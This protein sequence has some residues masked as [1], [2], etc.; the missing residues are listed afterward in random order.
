MV[1]EREI[2][3]YDHQTVL[4]RF[5]AQD[6]EFEV[7]QG[8]ISAMIS[9]DQIE[10]LIDGGKTMYTR[11]GDVEM[12]VDGLSTEF[13]SMEVVVDGATGEITSLKS[14][15]GTLKSTATAFESRLSS[16]EIDVTNLGDDLSTNYSTTAQMNSAIEQSAQGITQTVS[17][18]YQTKQAAA[19]DLSAAKTYADGAA[20]TAESNAATTAQN[21]VDS[22]AQTLRGE[23]AQALSGYTTLTAAQSMIDQSATGIRQ[24]VSGT[25]ITK[26][27]AANDIANGVQD[28]KDYADEQLEG[29]TTTEQY[30]TLSTT[31]DGISTE[32]GKKVGVSE[33]ISRINQSPEQIT[34]EASRLDLRGV[35]TVSQVETAQATANSALVQEQLIYLSMPAGTTSTP[36]PSFWVEVSAP[37]Q[38]TWTTT[39]PPYNSSYPV[40][41]V[42]TQ[43]KTSA[44]TVSCTTPV[45]DRTTTVIDGG[46]IIANSVTADKIMVN[47]VLAQNVLARDV[48]ASGL[49]DFNNRFYRL[50]VDGST[51]RVVLVSTYGISLS[52]PRIVIGSD[53]GSVININGTPT[54]NGSTLED[55]VISQA[56]SKD[57]TG[58]MF[59]RVYANGTADIWGTKEFSITQ[60][61][62]LGNCYRSKQLSFTIPFA[63]TYATLNLSAGLMCNA[64]PGTIDAS[65]NMNDGSNAVDGTTVQF[66]LSRGAA[67]PSKVKVHYSIHGLWK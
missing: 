20:S 8:K 22:M 19:S 31:V 34:I 51:S 27:A 1:L 7:V 24:E 52:G 18:T 54:I 15:V 21:K 43:R 56:S 57:S 5:T 16:T 14:D 39:R 66:Y 26:T 60:A 13:N 2:S 49:I 29:Y 41:F 48:A 50:Y 6:T 62:S 30:A 61:T 23:T 11:L 67:M 36:A 35:A 3:L 9:E 65:G 25:Y 40:L 33:V 45:I 37:S 58:G 47:D 46:A 42:A 38:Y 44:R 55:F 28:A 64:H 10:E 63:M 32:V 59:W 53:A 4:K 17:S 12:T